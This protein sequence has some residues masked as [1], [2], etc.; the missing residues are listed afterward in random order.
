MAATGDA[1]DSYSFRSAEAVNPPE[2]SVVEFYQRIFGP[3]FQ[4]PNSPNFKPDPRVMIRNSVVSSVMEDFSDLNK[5]LG[6]ADRARMDQYLT[7][8]R[9]LERRL[10]FQL[11]KPPSAGAC[12]IPAAA[13]HDP[14]VGQDTEIVAQRHKLM[15]DILV[16]A[17]A[18]NQTKVFNMVYSASLSSVVKTGY[19]GTHHLVTH[20]EPVD[21]KLGYQ[22]MNSW[23]LRRS[24]EG[25]AY[26]VSALASVKEGDGS[27]LDNTLVF[28]HSDTEQAQIH[29]LRGIPM[30]TAGRAGGRIKSG[31]HVDG[32]GE[33]GSRVG[34]TMLRAMG[35]PVVDWGAGSMRTDKVV[36][37]I[38][39]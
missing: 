38:V 18:C 8:L 24:M 39:T 33:P 4:D 37:E 26:F 35:V 12:H 21:P 1:H 30:M 27:L 17:L 31:L 7:S 16:M 23:F 5:T 20:E 6:Q 13:S 11:Q 25:W 29:S 32:G 36:S 15:T 9:D 14:P 19:S 22:P 3:D 2:V 34:F 28:A 10:E